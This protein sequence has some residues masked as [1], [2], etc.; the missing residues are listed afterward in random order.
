MKQILFIRWWEAFDKQEDYH[1]YLRNRS[2]DPF[3]TKKSRRDRI[4]RALSEEYEM[5]IPTMPCKQNA[6][7]EARKIRF[8][9]HFDY[10]NDEWCILIWHSLWG[11][12]LVKWL[13]ENTFP[14]KISQLH[15]VCSYLESKWLIGEWIGTFTAELDKIPDIEKQVDQIYIYHSKDDPVV[16]YQHSETL[17]SLLPTATMLTFENRWHFNQPALPELLEKIQYYT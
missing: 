3:A 1:N 5:M 13:S 10:L 16:P 4:G 11:S 12:F 17:A 14:K 15:L 6:E 9:R 2:F 8:E 7:Y